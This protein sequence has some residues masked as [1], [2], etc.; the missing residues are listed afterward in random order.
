MGKDDGVLAR[1]RMELVR[2]G[3]EGL[4]RQLARRTRDGDIESLR[5]VEPRADGGAA[6]G[7]LVEEG[8][9]G[10]QLLLRLLKHIEPAADLLHEGDGD[11]VLQMRA[12]RLD[13]AVVLCHEAAEGRGEEVDRGE[14]PV[15]DGDDGGDVHGGREGVVRALRHV[16]VIVWMENF[17]PR[18]LVAA[19]R[20]DLVDVHIGLRAAARLPY[21]EREVGGELAVEDFITCLADGGEPLFIQLAKRVVGDGGRLF[22]DAECVD[23]LGGHLLN[24]DGEVLEAALRL[25]RPVLVCGDFDLAEGIMLNA[26]LHGYEPPVTRKDRYCGVPSAYAMQTPRYA[27]GRALASLG[28]SQGQFRTTIFRQEQYSTKYCD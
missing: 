6:E 1:E 14:Q 4:A 23:D 26:I 16:R 24:A 2:C 28:V 11:G 25:R 18:D 8:E 5:C 12:S 7:K 22:Q 15:L 9:G 10:L 27:S 17:L 20:D 3:D 21:S 19:V 13:D